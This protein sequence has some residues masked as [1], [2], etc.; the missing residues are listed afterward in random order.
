M[1]GAFDDAP[2]GLVPVLRRVADADAAE[3]ILLC[4]QAA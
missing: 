1:S 3:A 2:R 4:R